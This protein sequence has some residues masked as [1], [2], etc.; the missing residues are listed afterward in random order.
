M[1]KL[2]IF[3]TE[4]TG[5]NEEDRIIQV[6]AIISELGNPNYFE[7]PYNE[8]CSSKI[9]IKIEAMSTHGIRQK[10][11]ENKPLFSE[12]EFKKRFEELNSEENYLIAHNLEF[13]KKMLEKEEY[14]DKINYK[15]IDTLQCAKHLFE[16]GEEING[17]KLPN[18]KLQTF[19][20]MM[21]SHEEEELEAKKYGVEIKAHDAIGDVVILKMF[22]LK[23]FFKIKEKYN[24]K[25]PQNIIDKMVELTPL[26]VEV[27]IITFGKYAGKELLEIE[28]IEPTYID[29]LYNEQEKQKNS[30]NSKFDKDLHYTLDKI[31]QKR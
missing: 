19:R 14:K 21:F 16:I 25:N 29:W 1:S 8:L 3:D 31:R 20:Y 17:Y 28:N 24:I 18:Y 26:P 7:K 10:D 11:I 2:I 27:K 4:T 6:G 9:P 13:D 23:L 15:L 22:L 30:K 5:L 12:T